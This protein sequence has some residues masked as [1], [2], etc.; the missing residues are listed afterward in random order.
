MAREGAPLVTFAGIL[1]HERFPLPAIL[2]ELLSVGTQA[3]ITPVELEFAVDLEPAPDGRTTFACLQMRP[4]PMMRDLS[5][6]DLGSIRRDCLLCQSPRALG[7]GRIRGIR[8]VVFIDPELFDRKD[9]RKTA[10]DVG[11]LNATLHREGRP[12]LLIGPGRWGSADPWLGIPV[13][14][15]QIGAARI[16]V[17]TGFSGLAVTPS[18][19]S[20]FFHNIVAFHIGYMTTNPERDEGLI[21][22]NW[23]QQQQVVR[24]GDNGLRWVQLEEPILGLIDGRTRTGVILKSQDGV[25]ASGTGANQRDWI[26]RTEPSC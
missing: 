2:K 23:L 19:G 4:L 5:R 9:S 10:G 18:E 1:K 7:N 20:H 14:W 8:D 3:M 25:T 24:S 11:E 22:W 13:N 15:G 6:I 12:Y 16:I 17:E 21:D 26:D